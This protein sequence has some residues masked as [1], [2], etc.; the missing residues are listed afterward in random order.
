MVLMDIE[1]EVDDQVDDCLSSWW[2]TLVF[3]PSLEFVAIYTSELT[4]IDTR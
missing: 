2:F 4:S 3:E 1:V